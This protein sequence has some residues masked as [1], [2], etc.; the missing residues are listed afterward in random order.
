MGCIGASSL[1]R[2]LN[3]LKVDP[4]SSF[5]ASHP[6]NMH[7]IK[8]PSF[9]S[10]QIARRSA[11]LSAIVTL[12]CWTAAHAVDVPHDVVD[13]LV[14]GKAIA[15]DFALETKNGSSE[16]EPVHEAVL[17]K[18]PTDLQHREPIKDVLSRPQFYYPAPLEPTRRLHRRRKRRKRMSS[19]RF[20]EIHGHQKQWRGTGFR[21]QQGMMM[22]MMNGKNMWMM[23]MMTTNMNGKNMMNMNKNMNMNM[24][25]NMWKGQ[26]MMMMMMGQGGKMMRPMKMGMAKKMA[27]SNAGQM[28][29][30]WVQLR[31][32][33][34]NMAQR[35]RKREQ[36]Q[37]RRMRRRK[38]RQQVLD[39]PRPNRVNNFVYF[40]DFDST[41]TDQDVSAST[42][43]DDDSAGSSSSNEDD[44]AG[45]SNEDDSVNTSRE[46]D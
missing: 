18:W 42:G 29:L 20:R 36:R 2:P 44:S 46:D 5:I 11:F 30:S 39:R 25:V 31:Q 37:N 43:S 40:I 1:L 8:G 17:S 34:R 32:I 10:R 15:E 19:T 24:N 33:R 28:R 7:G 27:M 21:Q 41:D 4:F 13:T 26:N 45:S 23:M 6:E 16:L 22:N 3:F 14:Q 35:E 38:W 12:L 9:S